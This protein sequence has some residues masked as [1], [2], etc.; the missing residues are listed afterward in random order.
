MTMDRDERLAAWLDGALPPDEAEAF[1]AEV[2]K[3]PALAEQAEAWRAHDRQ[4]SAAFGEA[5]RP[6]DDALLARLGLATTPE[7]ANDNPRTPALGWP[8]LGWLAAGSALAASLVAAVVITMQAPRPSDPL[9]EG[10]E[11]T[12]SLASTR[13][14]DGRTITPTLTVRAADGRWCREFREGADTALACRSSGRW[15]IEARARTGRPANPGAIAVASGADT[16][17]LDAAHA[18]LKT[19]DPLSPAE[20]G[21]MLANH[22]Q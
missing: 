18:K 11:R 6:V 16:A 4:I 8:V 21:R 1:A 20:E 9:S 5:L 17:P 7:P 2:A 12:A 3:D 19:A 15:T 14:A 13:L 22:W 10:L